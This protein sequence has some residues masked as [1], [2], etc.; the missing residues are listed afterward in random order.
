MD[1]KYGLGSSKVATEHHESHHKK[2]PLYPTQCKFCGSTH[3]ELCPT[4]HNHRC[5]DCGSLQNDMTPGY[6]TGRLSDY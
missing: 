2:T 6:A 5:A 4:M 3:L 1:N